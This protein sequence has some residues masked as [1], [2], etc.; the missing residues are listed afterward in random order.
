MATLRKPGLGAMPRPSGT[1]GASEPLSV[2]G[3]ELQAGLTS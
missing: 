1:S 2:P 3:T